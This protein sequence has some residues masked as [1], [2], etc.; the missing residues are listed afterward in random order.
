MSSR[1]EHASASAARIHNA[2]K[3]KIP[4]GTS[5]QSTCPG[6][7][8]GLLSGCV[9]WKMTNAASV[10]ITTSASTASLTN[11]RRRKKLLKPASA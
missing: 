2:N 7:C 1:V 8:P 3:I 10:A 4:A 9:N 11:G 6:E 5:R